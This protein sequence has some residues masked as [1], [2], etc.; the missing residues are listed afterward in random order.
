[1]LF[2][3]VAT[4]FRRQGSTEGIWLLL[5][6]NRV[7]SVILETKR[8]WYSLSLLG[9]GPRS[10]DGMPTE[11]GSIFT[12]IFLHMACPYGRQQEVYRLRLKWT[13]C[14][15]RADTFWSCF[16]ESIQLSRIFQLSLASKLALSKPTAQA[17][18]SHISASYTPTQKRLIIQL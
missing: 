12:V 1:M 7:R 17:L 5:S 8:R 6:T 16:D 3:A 11:Q 18:R 4:K 13:G 15:G 9:I 2:Q 14:S 10:P